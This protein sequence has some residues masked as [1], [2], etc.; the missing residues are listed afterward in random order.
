MHKVIGI[1]NN[2][3]SLIFF[4]TILVAGCLYQDALPIEMNET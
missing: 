1:M 2:F 4:I 3:I